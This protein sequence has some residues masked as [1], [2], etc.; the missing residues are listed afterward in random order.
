VRLQ[1][2]QDDEKL[3]AISTETIVNDEWFK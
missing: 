1:V 3:V 2:L